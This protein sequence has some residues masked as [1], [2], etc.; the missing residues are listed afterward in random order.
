MAALL[1]A[2]APQAPSDHQATAAMRRVILDH[3]GGADDIVALAL[4]CARHSQTF[5]SRFLLLRRPRPRSLR[6]ALHPAAAV[7]TQRLS[8]LRG[9]L[10]RY[11]AHRGCGR[12]S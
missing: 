7:D 5:P 6:G 2:T 4:L 3:D 12:R 10:S 11:G 1:N 8:E 9:A